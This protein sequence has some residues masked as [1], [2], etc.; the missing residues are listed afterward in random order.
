LPVI[1][2]LV[3]V[4]LFGENGW[5]GPWLGRQGIRV[6]FAFPGL[7][8]ATTFVTWP[9][10]VQ[11]LLALMQSQGV[12]QEAALT[13]GASGWQMF[14]RATA[15]SCAMRD[16]SGKLADIEPV[17]CDRGCGRRRTVW[18]AGEP[19]LSR[20]AGAACLPG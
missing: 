20:P 11:T 7:I 8:L 14:C 4:L 19:E 2:G 18:G 17:D 1:S 10:V 9:F 5:F 13:I 15:C 12:E 16:R 6:I 3:W